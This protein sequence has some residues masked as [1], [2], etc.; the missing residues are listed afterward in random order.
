MAATGLISKLCAAGAAE[1]EI[2]DIRFTND[3][4]V[5]LGQYNQ[6]NSR[7]K[8]ATIEGWRNMMISYDSKLRALSDEEI[9]MTI[10][11][12]DYFLGKISAR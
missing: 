11:L 8:T 6:R 10:E 7:N 2:D 1:R 5:F 3:F 9:R 12:L 4:C